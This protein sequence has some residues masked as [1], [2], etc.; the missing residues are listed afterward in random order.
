MTELLAAREGELG[1]ASSHI[2]ECQFCQNEIKKLELISTELQELPDQQTP[3]T[4]WKDIVRVHK[5]QPQQM[6]LKKTISLTR[7][8]YALAASILLVGFTA[9]LNFKQAPAIPIDNLLAELQAQSRALEYVL[10]NYPDKEVQLTPLQ[11][12]KVEQLQWQL[13]ML[14]KKLMDIRPHQNNKQL[15]AL[16][17]TR[18]KHLNT[19]HAAYNSQP[20][21][22][23][24]HEQRDLL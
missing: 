22:T 12:F 13:T 15:E 2:V 20:I 9:I 8:V 19:L 4:E 24:R 14:D 7:A 18:V 5:K 10:S 21:T 11:S 23:V 1:L 3:N 17:A 6:V 16:W